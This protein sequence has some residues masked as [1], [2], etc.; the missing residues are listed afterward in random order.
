[1]S[2]EN[3]T[4]TFS[5]NKTFAPTATVDVNT[6]LGNIGMEVLKGVFQAISKQ[7]TGSKDMSTKEKIV[8]L[9]KNRIIFLLEIVL[10]CGIVKRI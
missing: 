8:A 1:M 6:S 9:D 3:Q 4:L 10:F 2:K 5:K 7:I